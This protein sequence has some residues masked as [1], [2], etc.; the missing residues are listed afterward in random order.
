M[1]EPS[2]ASWGYK[3]AAA[4]KG[5]QAAKSELEKLDPATLTA[6]DAVK[7]AARIIYLAHEDSKDKDFELEMSWVSA[8]ET[9]GKHEFIPD[10]LLE[11]AKQYAIDEI[12]GGDDEMEE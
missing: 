2:G 3:G 7:H 12:S 4:G 11:E 10:S 9:G 5:R 8:S 1:I 6:R